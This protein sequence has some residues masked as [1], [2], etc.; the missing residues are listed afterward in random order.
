MSS[1]DRFL[2]GKSAIVSGAARGLGE[3]F[4]RRLAE[5]GANV[6][7]F[8]VLP[9]VETLASDI[10]ASASG[11]VA[12]CTADVSKRGDVEAV[13]NL[14]VAEFGGIDILV[15]NAGTWKETLVDSSWEE[16]LADWNFIM[17]TNVKGLLMLSRACVPHMQARGGGDIVNISSYYVLPA[18]GTGTNPPRTDLYSAS[19]WA[20]NGFTDAWSKY[21][22]KDNIRVNALCMGAT[23]SPMLRGLYPDNELPAAMAEVVMMPGQIAGLMMDLLK[24]GRTG[25]NVGAWV[26][27]PIELGPVKEP[28]KRITG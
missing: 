12:G 6:L 18:R 9:E 17:D 8:D 26:G 20:I 28:H 15:N 19:K 5:E 23:D 2:E 13:V 24:D 1:P 11:T 4:A 7:M 27:E 16:A 22:A 21:L 14:A 25:E 10:A 3:G